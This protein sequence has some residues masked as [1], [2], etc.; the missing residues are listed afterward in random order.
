M[1]PRVQQKCNEWISSL[2][3]IRKRIRQSSLNSIA[4]EIHLFI[5][6]RVPRELCNFQVQTVAANSNTAVVSKYSHFQ[7]NTIDLMELVPLTG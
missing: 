6:E 3:G 1:Q 7:L 4:T 5:N 2:N